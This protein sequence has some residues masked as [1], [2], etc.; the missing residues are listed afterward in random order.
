MKKTLHI[1]CTRFN[2]PMANV[3]TNMDEEWLKYRYN[4]FKRTALPSVKGQINKEFHWN[5][6][7][8][9]TTNKDFLNKINKDVKG[10]NCS[11]ILLPRNQGVVG[12]LRSRNYSNYDYIITSRLDTDDCWRF[13]YTDFVNKNIK[14]YKDPF[15]FNFVI[16][17]LYD[18]KDKKYY[19]FKW[20]RGSNTMSLIE[21]VGEKDI[22]TIHYKS[23]T[24]ILDHI[25]YKDII[26]PYFITTIHDLNSFEITRGIKTNKIKSGSFPDIEK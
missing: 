26:T 21:K 25:S 5:I 14:I 10:L 22:L 16:G 13:D 2:I 8:S 11:I 15:I 20:P 24:K 7:F 1:V 3:M 12:H 6:Y 17:Y 18:I 23:H 9:E 19:I 4:L